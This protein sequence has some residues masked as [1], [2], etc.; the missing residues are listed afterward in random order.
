MFVPTLDIDLAWHTHQLHPG[1]Y[2][3]YGIQNVGRIINHDDSI[4]ETSLAAGFDGTST[5]WR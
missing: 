3:N 2:Q 1:R 5:H 4:E